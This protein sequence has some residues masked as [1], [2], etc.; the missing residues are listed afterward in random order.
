MRS[1]EEMDSQVVAKEQDCR[2]TPK[3][4]VMSMSERGISSHNVLEERLREEPGCFL[5]RGSSS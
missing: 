5:Q 3:N 2:K 4:G 1:T